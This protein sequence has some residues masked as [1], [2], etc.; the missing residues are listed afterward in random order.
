MDGVVLE[1]LVLDEEQGLDAGE[2]EEGGAEL[3]KKE[4]KGET[5]DEALGS[6]N[7]HLADR[8]G[9]EAVKGIQGTSAAQHLAP[10]MFK[11]IL[12]TY[13]MDVFNRKKGAGH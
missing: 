2:H 9:Q 7:S 3:S 1:V 11:Q 10:M 13:K 4:V 12:A 5:L 8:S 6:L